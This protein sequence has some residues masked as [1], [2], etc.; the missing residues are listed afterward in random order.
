MDVNIRAAITRGL[1]SRGV[2]VLTAQE[3]NARTLEDPPL[4]DRATALGRLLFTNDA[5]LLGEA[6]RRQRTGEPFAGVAYAG[7]MHGSVGRWIADLEIIAQASDLA[8][9]MNQV[10][11]L[12]F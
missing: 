8:D 11:F 7:Q 10:Y 5:D 6:A 1:R 2:D 12:P 9:V 4:L 3:D